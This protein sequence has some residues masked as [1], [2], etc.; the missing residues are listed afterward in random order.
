MLKVDNANADSTIVL[1]GYPYETPRSPWRVQS[2]EA[3]E[4]Y[5]LRV[6]FRDGLS[7]LV[8]MSDRVHRE[9]A[10]VFCSLADPESFADV[11]VI[12]GAVTWGSGVDLAPDAMH[13]EIARNGVWVLR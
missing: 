6:T 4:G 13:D 9:D 12:F 3:L 1:D 2:V 5:Q 11:A 10:G 7:G 8:Q